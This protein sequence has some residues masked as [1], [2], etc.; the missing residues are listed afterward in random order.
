MI[1][2]VD[3]YDSF[4]YN[5]FQEL[6]VL[7]ARVQV[8]RND[9]VT[10]ESVRAMQPDGIVISPGPGDPS[11]AGSSCDLLRT[12]GGEVPVLGVCLGLQCIG[13]AFGGRVVRAPQLMHGKTSLVYHHHDGVFAGLPSPFE[14]VRY[15]S[16]VVDP[17]SL[18]DCLQITA[19]TADGTIMGLRHRAAAVDGVQFHPESVLTRDGPHLLR[20]FLVSCG[21]IPSTE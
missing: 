19:Q 17:D 2:L 9:A 18:P 5:L 13:A 8:R 6:S 11:E 4:T 20:N 21:E 1:L 12:F 3:N 16:L 14:A 10:C 15:H 7:G